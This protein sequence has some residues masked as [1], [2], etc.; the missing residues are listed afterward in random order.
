MKALYTYRPTSSDVMTITGSP[1]KAQ[2]PVDNL[3][4]IRPSKAYKTLNVTGTKYVKL[5]AGFGNKFAID[6]LFMN[7]FNFGS[8]NVQGSDDDFATTPFD[9][10]VTGVTP[11]EL[12]DPND[13]SIAAPKYM[14]YWLD[15]VAFDY[16][17][18]RVWIPSQTPI[19]DTDTFKIGNLLIGNSVTLWNPREGFRVNPTPMLNVTEFDSGYASSYRK[20]KT[21]RTFEGALDKVQNSE[22]LKYVQ[23]NL[24]FVLYLD[25]KSDPTAAYLVR[26]FTGYTHDYFQADRLNMEYSFREIV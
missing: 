21:F 7:R 22:F 23:T 3:R 15:L 20:G 6:S 11:D 12:Y 19:F 10:A 8:F 17:Y 25:W 14:H 26:S 4:D 9:V 13:T 18:L 2:F 16:R 5:D 1:A 24:P